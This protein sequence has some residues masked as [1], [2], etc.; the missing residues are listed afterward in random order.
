MFIDSQ[1]STRN[2]VIDENKG[3]LSPRTQ[4]NVNPPKFMIND[5]LTTQNNRE[6]TI[7]IPRSITK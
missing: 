1:K 5:Y 2:N 3:Y 7:P 6:N 4:M